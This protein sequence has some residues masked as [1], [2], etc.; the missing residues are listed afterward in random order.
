MQVGLKTSRDL[1]TKLHTLSFIPY[2]N[3]SFSGTSASYPDLFC[4]CEGH[5]KEFQ[6]FQP[7]IRNLHAKK[8]HIN[9]VKYYR[10]RA[11]LNKEQHG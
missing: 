9:T 5:R 8:I 4:V 10:E 6:N 3:I 1:E 11:C 7:N 2:Q